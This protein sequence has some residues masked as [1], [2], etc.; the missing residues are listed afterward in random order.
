MAAVI[1]PLISA[2]SGI[3]IASAAVPAQPIEQK[4]SA[5]VA[6]RDEV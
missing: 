5:N 4:A 1:T 2:A 6:T 3:E